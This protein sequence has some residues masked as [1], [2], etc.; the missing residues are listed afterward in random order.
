M[1]KNQVKEII[2][3]HNHFFHKGFAESFR[4]AFPE[5][6][7]KRFERMNQDPER[8]KFF[9]SLPGPEERA[10][11]MIE[12]MKV[13]G[14]DYIL[15]MTFSGDEENGFKAHK[16]YPKEFPGTVP[17]LFPDYHTDPEVLDSWKE[18]GAVAVKFYPAQWKYG[19]DDDRIEKYLDKIRDLGLGVL[20]HFGVVK[21]GD[22]RGTWPPNPLTLKPWLKSPKFEDMKF[23]VCHF[24]AGYLREVLMM[25]YGY[26][27]QI[28]VDTSGSNDWIFNSVLPDLTFVF[29]RTIEALQPENVYFGTDS[30]AQLLRKNVI[31]R[32]L[33]ILEDLVTKKIITDE[34]RWNILG[35]NTKRDILKSS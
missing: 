12:D 3:I 4:K 32:Q 6:F 11:Q 13:K 18:Q 26:P 7:T 30:N 1:S 35:G 21:G 17:M 34:D 8:M 23:I 19:F 22:Q 25:G 5:E 33:G 15:P 14:I 29:Q 28:A 10:K 27:K 31:D 24:G 16:T 9:Q 2:D 20:I